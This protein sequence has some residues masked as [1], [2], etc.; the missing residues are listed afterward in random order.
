MKN[1]IDIIIKENL[2]QDKEVFESLFPCLSKNCETI[3][4]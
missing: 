3:I 1:V 4:L 2:I